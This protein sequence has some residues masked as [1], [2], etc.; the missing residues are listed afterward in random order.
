MSGGEKV[1]FIDD[2]HKLFYEQKLK[3][4]GNTTDVYYKSIIYTLAICPVTRENFSDIFD[5]KNGEINID[6]LQKGYQTGSSEKT[7]RLAFSLWN[8]CN[9]DSEEDI[10]NNKPSIYYNP[11]EIFCC[12][13]A[14]YFYEAIRLR[15]PEYTNVANY[16]VLE[17]TISDVIKLIQAKYSSNI[18]IIL[19][20]NILTL[21]YLHTIGD[22]KDCFQLMEI[23]E[24]ENYLKR[25][26]QNC[27]EAER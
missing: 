18:T 1:K 10:K 24:F 13:Y 26:L 25:I 5:L 22:E 2:E 4:I 21:E 15:Y 16:N 19:T 23:K 17:N 11:S 27:K 12:S 7:T 14:P 20:D 3:E 6:S 9:Y 8:R